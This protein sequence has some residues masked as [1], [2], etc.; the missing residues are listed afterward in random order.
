MDAGRS[1]QSVDTSQTCA[2]INTFQVTEDETN[3]PV[4]LKMLITVI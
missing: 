2:S 3:F 1:P 4:Y